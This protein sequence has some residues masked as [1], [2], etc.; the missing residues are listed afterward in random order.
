M[1]AKIPL[2]VCLVKKEIPTPWISSRNYNLSSQ[3]AYIS[4][5]WHFWDHCKV[6]SYVSSS[7]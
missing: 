3:S 2:K 4:E 5:K 6:T 1:L 7:K